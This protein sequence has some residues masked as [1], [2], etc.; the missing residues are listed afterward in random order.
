MNKYKVV[1]AAML[2]TF[3]P[4]GIFF[5]I[6]TAAQLKNGHRSLSWPFIGG[7]VD[8]SE[9][10]HYR[11]DG[12][13][14]THVPVVVYRF[15]V[16]TNTYTSNRIKVAPVGTGKY[17]DAKQIIDKYPA[18]SEVRVYYD[19]NN[20]EFGL[21][22]PGISGRSWIGILGGVL[23]SGVGVGIWT[24]RKNISKIIH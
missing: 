24:F 11:R 9:I 19:P 16:G 12:G 4:I 22:E 23:F 13:G 18:G 1:P 5:L 17:S 14:T 21:L 8:S 10:T 3:V 7:M 15:T 20:P 6:L 2:L